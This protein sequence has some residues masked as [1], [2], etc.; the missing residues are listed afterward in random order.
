MATLE[1]NDYDEDESFYEVLNE[2]IHLFYVYFFLLL[3]KL[4]FFQ[5]LYCMEHG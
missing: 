4:G 1:S 5:M 2:P 3:C